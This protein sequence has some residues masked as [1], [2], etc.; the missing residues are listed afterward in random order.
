M[1]IEPDTSLRIELMRSPT[2]VAELEPAWSRLH[3]QD[4]RASGWTEPHLLVPFQRMYFPGYRP[5][6]FVARDAA[7]T[8]RGILP[9]AIQMR[10][11]GPV[12]S[13]RIVPLAG[14]QTP[15]PDAVIE[16]GAESAVMPAL[17]SALGQMS[18][19]ELGMRWVHPDSHLLHPE[20]GLAHALPELRWAAGDPLWTVALHERTK[21]LQGRARKE[22]SRCLRRLQE[23]G[24]ITI[25]WE[26]PERLMTAARDFV[27]LNSRLKEHQQ[28]LPFY[29][30]GSA[31]DDSP[32]WL[33]QE[34]AAGRADLFTIRDRGRLI[35]GAIILRH[36]M[37]ACG[38]RAA[39]EP[40]L[41]A[42]GLGIMVVTTAMESCRGRGD[43]DFDLAPGDKPYKA[44]WAS[45]GDNT[46]TLTATR[47]TWRSRL[48]ARW[49]A[50]RRRNAR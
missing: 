20:H 47:S 31:G 5:H 4:P 39:W 28:Q 36:R 34:S 37:H 49:L 35:A 46:M 9:L 27:D 22:M 33:Q 2:Q 30:L 12:Y 32:S 17:A 43:Q 16:P 18:W 41:A 50:L 3:Q 48:A 11:V 24:E 1:P 42:F 25:G 23:R 44:N 15:Y 7:G 13:R 26:P 45:R 14:T 6:V 38:F 40:T 29:R 19:D 8:V 10:R 21:L